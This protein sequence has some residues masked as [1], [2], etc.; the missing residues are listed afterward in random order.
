MNQNTE[1]E[2]D[3]CAAMRLHP[4]VSGTRP[5]LYSYSASS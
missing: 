2:N 4:D 5:I 1:Y 3:E